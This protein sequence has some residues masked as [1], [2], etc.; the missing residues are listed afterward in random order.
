MN[1]KQKDIGVLMLTSLG[2]HHKDLTKQSLDKQ[3]TVCYNKG[4][5]KREVNNNE[6]HH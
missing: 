1:R 6:L 2:K 4:T 5:N 3:P